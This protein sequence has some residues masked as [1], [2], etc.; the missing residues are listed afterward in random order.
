[1][2]QNIDGNI[3]IVGIS[4]KVF[5]RKC[6]LIRVRVRVIGA[7]GE[8]NFYPFSNSVFHA[9][10]LT[11][12][13]GLSNVI[14]LEPELCFKIC[15]EQLTSFYSGWAVEIAEKNCFVLGKIGVFYF[16]QGVLIAAVGKTLLESLWVILFGLED[17]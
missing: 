11:P 17:F 8:F 14:S 10:Y 3:S 9:L 12:G 13:G 2:V 7:G 1:M 15:L 4:L 6:A 16:V 5:D